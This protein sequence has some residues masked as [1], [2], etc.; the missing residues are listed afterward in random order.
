MKHKIIHRVAN[1]GTPTD[2][3][4]EL[5]LKQ[6]AAFV[7]EAG[8]PDAN[9]YIPLAL[10]ADGIE[11]ANV[12]CKPRTYS[13]SDECIGWAIAFL[14]TAEYDTLLDCDP[15]EIDGRLVGFLGLSG[16]A[17]RYWTRRY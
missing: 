4:D 9:D 13:K 11:V 14:Q 5:I 8:R 15:D 17:A 3:Y 16:D 2:A 10:I 1:S 6:I 12:L 7:E